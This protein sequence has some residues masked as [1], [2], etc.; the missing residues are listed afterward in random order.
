MKIKSFR[1][2]VFA[3]GLL[4]LG[5]STS[6]CGRKSGCPMNE[7]AHVQPNKKGKYKKSKSKSGL[8][9]KDMNKRRSR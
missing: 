9:P 3:L 8:F 6:A 5:L 7:N 4:F 2:L 1:Y